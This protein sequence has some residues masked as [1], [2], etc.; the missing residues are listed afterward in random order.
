MQIDQNNGVDIL[1]P[2]HGQYKLV[3][4]LIGSIF[5]YTRNIPFR[6]TII[7]DGSPNA[8]YFSTLAQLESIDGVRS[9][10]CKGLG[11]AL[12]LGLKVTKRP[13]VVILNSD[14]LIDE[15]GW[16][17]GL[18]GSLKSMMTNKV[19]LVSARSNNPPGN[20]SLLKCSKEN[21]KDLEDQVSDQPLPLFCCM[22]PRLLFDRVGLFKE[23]PYGWYEDEEFFYRMKKTGYH[24][25]ISGTSWVKHLGEG[26]S[27][28][29]ELWAK[30]PEI[31]TIMENNRN[32]CL[33]DLK[34]LFGRSSA[35]KTQ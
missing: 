17:H 34:S 15:V 2:Y 18:Y 16:L 30:N 25:G 14:C 5:L 28:I 20:H 26:G 13:W 19:G 10:E 21:R 8:M 24:Q 1:I 4:E 22:M 27:T 29:Q 11:A 31:K 3:R 35:P 7:D 32:L 33:N 12:N 6:I 23:Y 9:E